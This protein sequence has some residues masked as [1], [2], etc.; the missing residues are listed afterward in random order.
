MRD[1]SPS[2]CCDLSVWTPHTSPTA[3]QGSPVALGFEQDLRGDSVVGGYPPASTTQGP[4]RAGVQAPRD[5]SSEMPGGPGLLPEPR[6]IGPGPRRDALCQPRK[7]WS[8]FVWLS[9]S[10]VAPCR[11]A[12]QNTFSQS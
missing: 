8:R 3:A 9:P 10:R 6:A 7:R 2:R 5:R 12:H 4:G 11:L 1:L